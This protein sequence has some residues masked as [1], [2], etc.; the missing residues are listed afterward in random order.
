MANP[1][2]SDGLSDENWFPTAPRELKP[3][4]NLHAASTTH[5]VS[6]FFENVRVS[7][8]CHSERTK[9]NFPSEPL[10]EDLCNYTAPCELKPLFSLPAASS[11]HLAYRLIENIREAQKIRQHVA[12]AKKL[13]TDIAW[14]KLG[15]FK[16]EVARLRRI[17]PCAAGAVS[18]RDPASLSVKHEF[19]RLGKIAPGLL[20]CVGED[21]KEAKRL[22]KITPGLLDSNYW[23][24]RPVSTRCHSGRAKCNFPSEPLPEDLCNSMTI[25]VHKLDTMCAS[26]ESAP[27]FDPDTVVEEPKPKKVVNKKRK[28]LKKAW[29]FIRSGLHK[30][31]TYTVLDFLKEVANLV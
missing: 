8:P 22:S 25:H 11:T 6:L 7:T 13:E 17:R 27:L 23:L 26:T 2:L 4:F 15:E 3:L 14:I 19:N 20:C 1:P 12:Q 24:H 10:P 28:P 30:L 9:C 29:R 16:L 18:Q 21:E 5:L 31:R